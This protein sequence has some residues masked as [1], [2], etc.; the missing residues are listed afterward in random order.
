MPLTMIVGIDRIPG[1][2]MGE[3]CVMAIGLQPI[4]RVVVRD[5][6]TGRFTSLTRVARHGRAIVGDCD[7]VEPVEFE[8]SPAPRRAPRVTAGAV[9][10][11]AILALTVA[12]AAGA[13]STATTATEVVAGAVSVVTGLLE[14]AVVDG[15]RVVTSGAA[16]LARW[17][18]RYVRREFVAQWRLGLALAPCAVALAWLALATTR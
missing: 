4:G 8:S 16:R 15:A 13:A 12:V 6:A 3:L 2:G 7:L 14:S 9:A 18:V 11:R 17:A 5:P 1:A 10:A